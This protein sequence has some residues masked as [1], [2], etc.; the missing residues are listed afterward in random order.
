MQGT[1]TASHGVRLEEVAQK[2]ARRHAEREVKY[3]PRLFEWGCPLT[4][5]QLELLR[6]RGL[7][8]GKVA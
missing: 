1:K 8:P 3:G 7:L 6:R 4:T 2:T 5:E